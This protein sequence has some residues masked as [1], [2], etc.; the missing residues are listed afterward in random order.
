MGYPFERCVSGPEMGFDGA[1]PEVDHEREFDVSG[2]SDE[3]LATLRVSLN[4]EVF[5]REAAA[6]ARYAESLIP[7]LRAGTLRG[8]QLFAAI[9][10]MT[11]AGYP[12]AEVQRMRG[13][14]DR[15]IIK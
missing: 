6:R 9:R 15:T 3:Q 11:D 2:L 10:A 12:L 8:E 5:R 14:V 4:E 7:E 1:E 13:D